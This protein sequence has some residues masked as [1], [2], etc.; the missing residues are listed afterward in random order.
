MS[1]WLRPAAAFIKRKVNEL[2]LAWDDEVG[3]PSFRLLVSD[4]VRRVAE[5]DPSR[6]RWNVRGSEVTVWVDA[7]SLAVGA[8]IAVDGDVIEDASWLRPEDCGHI[9]MAELDAV[10][11]GVNMALTWGMRTL[12]LKTDSQ[13]VLRWV[14]DALTGRSRLRTKAASEMLV[15]RRLSILTS[16]VEEYGLQ[17]DV[18][19]VPSATNL[20]DC[21]TRVPKN[22]LRSEK[23]RSELIVSCG[24]ALTAGRE[25]EIARVHHMT[26]HQGV[27]R[28]LYFARKVIPDAKVGEV[29]DIIS[30]CEPCQSIDPA[31]VKWEKGKLSVDRTWARVGMD[32]THYDG[33]HFLTLIDHGP[34]RFAVWRPLRR[35]DSTCVVEQL[36]SI[37]LE[38]GAPDEILT[39]NDT[40]FKSR[41]FEEFA[42]KWGIR[43]RFRCAHVPSGNGIT[44]RAHRTIKRIA[45]R[46]KCSVLEAVFLYNL[47][48]KDG[49]DASST[50]ASRVHSY[51]WRMP[52]VD[53]SDPS[54]STGNAT[55]SF[56]IG[57]VVWVK[58]KN[59]RCTGR[60]GTGRVTGVISSQAIEVDGVPRH[61][62]DVRL[63]ADREVA[64]PEEGDAADGSGGDGVISDNWDASSSSSGEEESGDES[65]VSH[66]RRPIRNVRLPDWYG[67][68]LDPRGL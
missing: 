9:N 3:D 49:Q 58:P 13:T 65:V 1:S 35:Q 57:D 36:E 22:W 30:N 4:M 67:V 19:F 64:N 51:S 50:P 17:M 52:G 32:I 11:K 33:A 20:A 47:S 42:E 16:L 55:S 31:P 63:A 45:V 12:H 18:S 8:V 21:L 24:A 66:S 10:I 59:Y 41:V 2:T 27:E 14:T 23:E 28:S 60:F 46:K 62:R 53:P 61:V 26:G 44:E 56:R 37:F 54:L 29:R 40:A 6:G 7:S 38:R 68:D 5:N 43:M 34:S 39:D 15:R 48:P 25:E